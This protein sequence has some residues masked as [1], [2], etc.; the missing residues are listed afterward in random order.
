VFLLFF[1]NV[2]PPISSELNLSL[3]GFMVSKPSEIRRQSGRRTSCGFKTHRR[4]IT[5]REPGRA[6]AIAP[7]AGIAWLGSTRK[8]YPS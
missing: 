5:V 3:A 4:V 8:S 7:A 6:K 1:E 2:F